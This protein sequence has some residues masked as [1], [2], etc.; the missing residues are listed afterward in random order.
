MPEIRTW[1][2]FSSQFPKIHWE[3]R[4]SFDSND[5]LEIQTWFEFQRTRW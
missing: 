4:A 2:E 3:I 5:P 1:F